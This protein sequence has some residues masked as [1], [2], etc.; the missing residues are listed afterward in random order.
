VDGTL[1]SLV[2][3]HLAAENTKG[4][5]EMA[6]LT[7]SSPNRKTIRDLAARQVARHPMVAFVVLAYA[8]TWITW[9]LYN[10][11]DLGWVNGIGILSLA[12][13]AL[14]AMIVSAYLGPEPSGIPA[15]KRLRSFGVV[16]FLALA[17][18]AVVRLWVAAGRVTLS[19]VP[20]APVAYPT[21]LAFL[22]DVLAAAVVAL[23]FSGVRSPRLGVSELLRS[24][25]VRRHPVR[26]YWWVFAVGFYPVFFA[27]GNALSAAVGLPEPAPK[28]SG[29]WYWLALE[30]LIMFVY[31]L[32]A[33]GGL[34]EPG[35][36]GFVLPRL[37]QR[38]SPLRAS[39]ILA[40][41]WAVWHWP[42][43]Q[44]GL[45][46]LLIFLLQYVAPAAILFTA[47]FNRTGGS[48][49]IAILLH[50]SINLSGAYLPESTLATGLWLLLILGLAIWMW[51]SPHRFSI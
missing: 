9:P 18:M 43:L 38:Y 49:P 48:L 51:R 4:A 33:G 36:R 6:E 16:G 23:I 24:L 21:P 25:D 30:A 19:G 40:L 22:G 28:A 50:A 5:Q 39:L 47:V 3:G 10:R 27:L 37:Q 14:A 44:G 42:M 31:Y 29:P 2:T 13:P 15:G 46:G 20:A 41:I 26:W 12:G 45:L 8:I 35:W 1:S 17:V 34:E 7:H 11:I 32:F